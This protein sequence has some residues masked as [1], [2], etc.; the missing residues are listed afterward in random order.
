[1]K[2]GKAKK[3]MLGLIAQLEQLETDLK[4]L[5]NNQQDD[6]LRKLTT[7]FNLVSPWQDRGIKEEY[8]TVVAANRHGRYALLLDQ[9]GILS[10]HFH[11]AGR[12][13]CGI[14]RTKQGEYVTE[15]N[16][17][18]GNIYGLFTL[19]IPKWRSGKDEPKGNWGFPGMEKL[20]AYDVVCRQATNFASGHIGPMIE[21]I[22]SIKSLVNAM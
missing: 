18:L 19:S 10:G 15:G 4:Q 7:L 21:L 11:N 14:N 5:K 16:V 3:A 20:N 8:D 12:D 1:M 2:K 6:P 9:L 22:Q 17:F 13:E